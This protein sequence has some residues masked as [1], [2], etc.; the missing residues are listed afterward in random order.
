MT[1]PSL[2]VSCQETPGF[3]PTFPTEQQQVLCHTLK[4]NRRVHGR[5]ART[6]NLL[7]RAIRRAPSE[8]WG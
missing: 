5:D 1:K 2:L 7:A 6:G 8:S 4:P 3:I